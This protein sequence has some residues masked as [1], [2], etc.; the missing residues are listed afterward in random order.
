M[1]H[2]DLDEANKIRESVGRKPLTREQADLVLQRMQ[3]NTPVRD[4]AAFM[5]AVVNAEDFDG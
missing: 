5:Q 4:A 3:G 2:Y 1:A